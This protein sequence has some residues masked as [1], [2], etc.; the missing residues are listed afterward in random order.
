MV[1]HEDVRVDA[2]LPARSGLSQELEI[3][4]PIRVTKKTRAPIHAA[5]RNV[6]RDA[7]KL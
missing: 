3:K 1:R 2:A 4:P 5:L 6:E 7:G